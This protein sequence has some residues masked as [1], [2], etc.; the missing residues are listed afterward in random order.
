MRDLNSGPVGSASVANRSRFLGVSAFT[1][2]P[3]GTQCLRAFRPLEGTLSVSNA[4][5]HAAFGTTS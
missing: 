3:E 2:C 1:S 4:P 5:S